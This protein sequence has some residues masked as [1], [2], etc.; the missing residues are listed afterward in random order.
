VG[1]NIGYDANYIKTF[2]NWKMDFKT[3]RIKPS[4]EFEHMM[5][6]KQYKVFSLS[7]HFVDCWSVQGFKDNS[8]AIVLIR[9]LFFLSI[10]ELSENSVS[11]EQTSV[12]SD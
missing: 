9:V 10:S 6:N 1:L 4:Q 8:T 11:F 3:D 7:D 5:S 2:S 12:A